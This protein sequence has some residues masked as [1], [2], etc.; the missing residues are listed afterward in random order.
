MKFEQ[1]YNL[2][3]CEN[4][5]NEKLSN[6]RPIIRKIINNYFFAL[7]AI[8][9]HGDDFKLTGEHGRPI[10]IHFNI[11]PDLHPVGK[12][13][14]DLDCTFHCHFTYK[15]TRKILVESGIM[16]WAQNEDF[17]KFDT[18]SLSV[19]VFEKEDSGF[20]A[21]LF[22]VNKSLTDYG[23]N[24]DEDSFMDSIPKELG[25]NWHIGTIQT[26]SGFSDPNDP[27][28]YLITYHPVVKTPVEFVKF[29][30]AILDSSD[31]GGGEKKT[32]KSP[33]GLS[34]P[35]DKSQPTTNVYKKPVKMAMA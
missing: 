27:D 9:E 24:F 23:D 31:G 6:S 25:N 16:A 18:S 8:L 28:P 19:S 4:H 12:P 34:K 21:S 3:I 5:N 22:K 15:G 32:P 33:S 26:S 14:Q 13:P 29:V 20:G 30:Q 2:L 17:T 7:K 10:D 35:I 11:S 1:L